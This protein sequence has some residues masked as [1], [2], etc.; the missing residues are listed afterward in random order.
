MHQKHLRTVT[1]AGLATVLM[2]S[3]A[4]AIFGQ[5]LPQTHIKT[6]GGAT[7]MHQRGMVEIPFFTK[8]LPEQSK[9]KVTVDLI[10]Y[11][12]VGLGGTEILRL[13][14]IGAI[15]FSRGDLIVVSNDEPR[16]DGGD[17][18]GIGMV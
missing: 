9:G 4:T 6:V 10:P 7:Y 14:K 5:D 13:M 12:T 1:A 3:P 8:T 18:A 15:E 11:D 16:F 2:M 17:L